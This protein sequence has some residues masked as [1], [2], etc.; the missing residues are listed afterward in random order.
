MQLEV[1]QMTHASLPCLLRVWDREDFHRSSCK[2]RGA[3]EGEAPSIYRIGDACRLLGLHLGLPSK[4]LHTPG[5][6]LSLFSQW[7]E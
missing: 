2:E 5:L 3:R 1:G 7:V 4:L 6:D